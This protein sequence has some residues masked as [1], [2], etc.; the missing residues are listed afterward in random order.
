MKQTKRLELEESI[1]KQALYSHSFNKVEAY[2][3][4]KSDLTIEKKNDKA[5]RVTIF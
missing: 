1:T 3:S 4:L 5:N 2:S